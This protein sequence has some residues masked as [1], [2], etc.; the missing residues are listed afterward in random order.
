MIETLS[1]L[2]PRPYVL[3][4]SYDDEVEILAK[5]T[6]FDYVKIKD[7]EKLYTY[8]K[9]EEFDIAITAFDDDVMNIAS[10]KIAK[11]MGIPITL[12]I[13]HNE[14]NKNIFL[15][16]G[17]Q[18]ILNL[19]NFVTSNIKLALMTDIWVITEFTP[20]FHLVTAFHRI[21]KRS[22]LGLDLRTLKESVDLHETV[23]FV[24]DSMGRIVDE[25][26]PLENGNILIVLGAKEK[27][28]KTINDIEKVF[29]KYEQLYSIRFADTQRS[30]GYG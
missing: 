13:L 6:G 18:G 11:S 29:R 25:N 7:I 10:I 14:M 21:V 1:L 2:K 17:V 30:S 28:L 24:V 5:S 3:I 15:K 12:S 27:V 23:V 22:V 26:K 9:L 8:E 19:D 16:E 20:F 4:A